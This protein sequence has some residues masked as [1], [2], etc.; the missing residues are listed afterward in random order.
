MAAPMQMERPPMPPDV[1]AQM[2]GGDGGGGFKG[3]GGMMADKAAAGNPMKAALDMTEKLWTNVVK[4]NPKL[5][6]YVARAL[7]ILK[8]G[9]EESAGSKPDAQQGAENGGAV[10]KGPDAG[11]VPA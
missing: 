10:P 8:A 2:G 9:L 11:N 5:G 7:A 4:G 6:S 1:Q 3:V